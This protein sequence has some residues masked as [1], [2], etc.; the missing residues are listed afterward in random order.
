LASQISRAGWQKI[1]EIDRAVRLEQK[2]VWKGTKENCRT[3]PK[4]DGAKGLSP[5]LNP[6]TS[7]ETIKKD[8]RERRKLQNANQW[9]NRQ[10]RR[11]QR[12]QG[13][14]TGNSKIST[15]NRSTI[16]GRGRLAS[17]KKCQNA[18]PSLYANHKKNK[19]WGGS[20]RT[21]PRRFGGNQKK[22][23]KTQ[24]KKRQ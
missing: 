23:K 1:Q 4:R 21:L 15:I 16:R 3:N 22:R 18:L 2:K 13:R 20:K 5:G 10:H 7:K 6:E 14:E 9:E 11:M 17:A 24:A 19:N 12:E 8:N